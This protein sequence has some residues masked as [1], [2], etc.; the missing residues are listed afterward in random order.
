MRECDLANSPLGQDAQALLYP[1]HKILMENG[2]DHQPSCVSYVCLHEDV[3]L[4]GSK[5]Q[6][7]ED[8]KDDGAERAMGHP[9]P[10]WNMTDDSKHLMASGRSRPEAIF[11]SGSTSR[12]SCEA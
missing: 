5:N 8:H 10:C 4:L 7:S 2:G 6:K 3:S 11:L 9:E 12:S 1:L